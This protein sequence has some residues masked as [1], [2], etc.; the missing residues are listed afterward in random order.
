M[1]DGLE[2][3][4][5]VVTT[6]PGQFPAAVR[7]AQEEHLRGISIRDD[8]PAPGGPAPSCDLAD[9]LRVPWID[10]V[11]IAPGVARG[12]ILNFDAI[13]GL[14]DLRELSVHDYARLDLTRTPKLE[15]LFVT[16]GPE[17]TGLENLPHL[18]RLQAWAWRRS[19]L[20]GLHLPRLTSL[21]LI[22]A[23]IRSL[24]GLGHLLSLTKLELSH[25]RNIASVDTVPPGLRTLRVVS[26]PRFDDF[27]FLAGN[28]SIDF[29]FMSGVRSLEFVPSMRALTRIGFGEVTGGDLAP[30]L[31][32]PCLREAFFASRK[33]YRPSHDEIQR[34][35]AQRAEST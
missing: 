14:Q 32:S 28:S 1:Q 33:K 3:K 2:V 20:S 31:Q 29:L 26:C 7:R 21:T 30:L 19:D 35:L 8:I 12:R 34:A 9:L 24:Q 5:G 22:Q 15:S 16:D 6:V 11:A 13:Y 23:T 10:T 4:D 17:L 27:T 18:Q 25:C